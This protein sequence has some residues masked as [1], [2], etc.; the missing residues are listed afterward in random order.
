MWILKKTRQGPIPKDTKYFGCRM[1]EIKPEASLLVTIHGAR[2]VG[3][4]CQH[5]CL[6]VDCTCYAHSMSG[7]CACWTSQRTTVYKYLLSEGTEGFLHRRNSI[8]YQKSCQK[9]VGGETIGSSR[10]TIAI[11]FLRG[12]DIPVKSPSEHLCLLFWMTTVVTLGQENFV[13]WDVLT[14]EHHLVES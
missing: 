7:Q 3:E 8:R 6:T 14:E 11:V 1:W 2:I 5:S 13:Q 9:S 4:N 12:Y 10:L